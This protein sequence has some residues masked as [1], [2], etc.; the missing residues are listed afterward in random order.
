MQFEL[1][2]ESWETDFHCESFHRMMVPSFRQFKE[3][4]PVVKGVILKIIS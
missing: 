2:D 1:D 3:E 4:A